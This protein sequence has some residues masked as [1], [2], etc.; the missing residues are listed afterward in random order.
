VPGTRILRNVTG[1]PCFVEKKFKNLTGR[2]C[3][4]GKNFKNLAGRLCFVEKNFKNLTGRPCFVEKNFKKPTGRPSLAEKSRNL[5]DCPYLFTKI[6]GVLIVA[7]AP[8]LA[9]TQTEWDARAVR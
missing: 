1:R 2:P 6:L 8:Q 4:A 3:F 5:S 7:H 9:R